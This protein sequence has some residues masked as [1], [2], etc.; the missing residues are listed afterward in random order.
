MQNI[1]DSN[2]PV[3]LY[4]GECWTM[5]KKEENL[6]RRTEIRMFRWILGVSLK[7]KIRND[8]QKKMWCSNHCRE[9]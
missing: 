6:L 7:D 8:D 3:L 4:E 5:R 1:Q 9:V 2:K